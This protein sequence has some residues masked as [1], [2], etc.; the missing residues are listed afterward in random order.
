[1]KGKGRRRPM[2]A[3][4]LLWMCVCLM[5]MSGCAT[6]GKKA[7]GRPVETQKQKDRRMAWWREAK[8]GMFIHW[9]LY[10]VPA[11]VWKGQEIPGIGEWIM[12]RAA[13]PVK[14]YEELA[15]QFNP[16]RFN[17]EE[18]VKTA[19]S[20]GMKYIVITA[21][22]HDGFAMYDSTASD[23][24]IVKA[25][26]FHRDPMKELAA[27]CRKEGLHLCFY[28]SHARDW[29]EP[30]APDN[31]WDFPDESRKDFARY[32]E[33]KAK[34]QVRELLRQYGPIGLMWF[35]TPIKISEEQSKDLA[36]LVHTL[37][38]K[39]LVSGRVGHGAGDYEQ[40]GDNKIPSSAPEGPWETPA[41]INDTWGF[42]K[43]DQNWK[44]VDALVFKLADIVSK[45]GNYL[46]NVGPTAEGL[47][48]QPS[49]DRLAAV[50]RWLKVNG[51][52]IYGAG[53]TPLRGA[54]WP[55][56]TKPGQLYVHLFDWPKGALEIPGLANPVQKA[57]LLA[58][59][60]RKALAVRQ[61]EGKVVVALPAERPDPIDSVLVLEIQGRPKA[62]VFPVGQA[63]A[64]A[65]RLKPQKPGA[66]KRVPE[67]KKKPMRPSGTKR[68]ETHR[69]IPR[70][71]VPGSA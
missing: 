47:I 71:A 24:N 64:G 38:P 26:P 23:Y 66:V 2:A 68:P 28:Y 44:S 14:E 27:A 15:P 58:D 30:D 42:K 61:S 37:Q 13:I 35:D 56:T 29:H 20:A 6:A 19:K 52:S 65:V 3:R 8:F 18:W 22:H 57:W 67:A 50:G 46:L 1:M 70:L 4:C 17:A 43:N 54:P 9:G 55:I 21:K 63:A 40:M 41:T 33:A 12:K 62:G 31:N 36:A 7:P 53:P 49:V 34:P 60:R 25:T 51:E 5:A 45:G 16:T 48:P 59:P 11:G 32:F 39:C 10:A 69:R